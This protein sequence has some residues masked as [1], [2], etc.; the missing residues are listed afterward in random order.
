MAGPDYFDEYEIFAF[1]DEA[2]R[3]IKAGDSELAEFNFSPEAS[4]TLAI[5]S[6][7]AKESDWYFRAH[8]VDDPDGIT[9][10]TVFPDGRKWG[11]SVRWPA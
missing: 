11:W 6:I 5:S 8:L 4:Y 7:N 1:D 10:I 9:V 3:R 2:L